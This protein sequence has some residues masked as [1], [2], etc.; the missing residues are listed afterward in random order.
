[1]SF[2]NSFTIAVNIDE[3]RQNGSP[4]K[5]L[6]SEPMKRAIFLLLL[7]AIVAAKL[8]AQAVTPRIGVEG[9]FTRLKP[10]GT[11]QH[12][13]IDRLDLP[14][15]GLTSP[16]LFLVFPV[17]PR[18]AVEPSLSANRDKFTERSGLFPEQTSTEVRLSVRADVSIASGLYIAGGGALRY[19]KIDASSALQPAI[20][21][22]I[23][24]QTNLSA[25]LGARLEARWM[26]QRRTDSI[27]PSNLYALLLGIS[28][29]ISRTASHTNS[30]WGLRLGVMG[31]YVRTHIY[32]TTMGFYVDVRETSLDFP[33]TGSTT[34][35][36]LFL[37][38]P[39]AG[40]FALESGFDAHREQ[41]QGV[42]FFDGHVAT[43]LDVAISHGVYA[44]AGGNIR[45]LEQTGSAGFALA[46]ANAAIGY[47][48]PLIY[49]LEG[50]TEVSYT[51]FKERQNFPFAQNN[52]AAL[53]G[54][55]MALN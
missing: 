39:L 21:A 38:V 5:A 10:A 32:G 1:M 43:R 37:V 3:G 44:A 47:R 23:G 34:P 49:Q 12:D 18:I 17:T 11:G 8:P 7:D 14:G 15:S 22:A 2:V 54:V 45:Y 29:P 40:R 26:S 48:F 42:T 28:S 30:P 9:G 46:G 53:L 35:A 16:I 25:S 50:R 52:L 55:A 13:Y 33:G 19:R 51:V 31:G 6:P 36:K 27:A 20:L 4:A 24:Y 41:Q